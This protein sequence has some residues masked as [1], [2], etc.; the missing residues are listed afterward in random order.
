[1]AP[2][3]VRDRDRR[4]VAGEAALRAVRADA[5]TADAHGLSRAWGAGLDDM[6]RRWRAVTTC[7]A[8]HTAPR[9]RC[10][11]LRTSANECRWFALGDAC[12]YISEW[13]YQ[14]L[15]DDVSR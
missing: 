5:I 1:M 4:W 3:A 6:N 13:G 11:N 12:K 15:P 2:D 14:Q 9:D 10:A 8:G 7:A